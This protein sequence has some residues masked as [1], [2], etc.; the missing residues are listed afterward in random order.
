MIKVVAAELGVAAGGLDVKDAIGNA[1]QRDIKGAPT[2]I[3]DQ[4][5]LGAAAIKAIGQGCSGWLIEDSLNREARKPAGIPGGLALG[6]IEI[7][8][9]RHHGGLHLLAEIGGSVIHQLAQQASHQFLRG[10]FALGS[11]AHHPHLTQVIGP[12]GVGH[13]LGGLI[14][15]LPL[16]PNQALQVGK[17]VA[18]IEHQLAACRLTH[19]QFFFAAEP[20]H[21][22]GRAQTFCIGHHHR[23]A[24]FQDSQ[25]GIGGAQI[26]ADD[27]AHAPEQMCSRYRA[28]DPDPS[29]QAS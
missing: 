18:R 27:P 2:Q 7:G 20:N 13:R 28:F 17:A 25:H 15:L 16:P 21:R 26:N 6:I 1:Q 22:R 9:N 11:R 5:G 12:D 3:E 23:P 10:V 29:T 14:E 19:Q 8:G 4:N 24:T